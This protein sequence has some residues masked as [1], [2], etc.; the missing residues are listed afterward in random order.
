MR[1][2]AR[3]CVRPGVS[4]LQE[5]GALDQR[6]YRRDPLGGMSKLRVQIRTRAHLARAHCDFLCARGRA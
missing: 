3:A 2:S 1:L 5:R 4:S 6:P